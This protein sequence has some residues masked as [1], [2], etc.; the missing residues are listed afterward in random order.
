MRCT[1]CG[2]E[3]PSY[4]VVCEQCGEFLPKEDLMGMRKKQENVPQPETEEAFS[5][6]PQPETEE[7]FPEIPQPETEV[8]SP[9]VPGPRNGG[10]NPVSP[11]MIRCRACFRENPNTAVHCEFCGNKLRGGKASETDNTAAFDILK[12]YRDAKITCVECGTVVP[13]STI[14]CP[15][16]GNN[17]RVGKSV[18]TT[19]AEALDDEPNIKH[20]G[21]SKTRT[22]QQ[23]VGRSLSGSLTGVLGKNPGASSN[24][25]RCTKCWEYSI[26]S[27]DN[28]QWCGASLM[29]YGVKAGG[30]GRNARK[31]CTCGYKNLPT[32]TVCVRCGGSILP[33][34]VVL[35]NQRKV[36]TC[37]YKNLPGV[38]I[39]LKCKQY[40]MKKC[41]HCGFEQPANVTVCAK[42]KQHVD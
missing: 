33:E 13:W 36:C 9:V 19:I 25:I 42:C 18:L 34:K 7:A 21:W 16:C 17:P 5:E 4:A 22:D 28:C 29:K 15:N 10:A 40:V 1:N 41:S 24:T 39:C 8:N 38:T 37:G 11:G 32:V 26:A 6:I 27:A 35:P 2:C 12:E 30:R 20:I 23:I 3:N 31:M 14:T